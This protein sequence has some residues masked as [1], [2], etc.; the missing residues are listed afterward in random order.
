MDILINQL[1]YIFRAIFELDFY[2]D[3]WKESITV[4]LC[5][6]SKPSYKD[7]KAYRP[8]ALLNTLGKLFLVILAD[9]L[10]HFCET[11]EAL[12]RNQFSG[13]LAWTTTDLMLL[14]THMIKESWRRKKVALVL[15]LDIQGAFPNIVKE[16]LI[17]NMRQQSVPTEYTC[18]VELMLT[19]R[20]T[21]LSLNS[22]LLDLIPINNGNNQGCPLSIIYYA[23]Y[24]AGLL[25]ISPP[26]S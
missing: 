2:P 21:Q 5:K 11:R 10:S 6:P 12:P 14:M 26:G 7:P 8:I 24:N 23:F 1:Y 4:V 13:R 17:H 18:L 25:E 9:D 15:F 3:K 16:V 20:K 22:F 19:G